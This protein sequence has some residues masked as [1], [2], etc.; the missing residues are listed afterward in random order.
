MKMKTHQ[1]KELQFFFPESLIW[2]VLD[3]QGV[4]LPHGMAFV[5]LVID[6]DQDV[7]LVE[8]KDPSHS[9][10]P[11]KEKKEY[12]KRLQDNS[13][14]REELT[15]KARD[16]YTFLHLMKRDDKPIKYVILLG[17]DAFDPKIQ[18]VLLANFKDRLLGDIQNEFGT[19]WK[20]KHIEDCVVFSVD[21]WNSFFKDWPIRRLSEAKQK[22]SQ[23]TETTQKD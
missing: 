2:E 7:L 10:A 1:E 12:L 15:P 5:D 9:K 3:K 20:R 6:R 4:K 19:P 16:S 21:D 13:V 23:G 18:K 17:L 14:L 22:I 8:I 11:N